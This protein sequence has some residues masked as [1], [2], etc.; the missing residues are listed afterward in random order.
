M[1]LSDTTHTINAIA[2]YGMTIAGNPSTPGYDVYVANDT[3]SWGSSV[4]SNAQK[5]GYFYI[6]GFS[7]QGRYV[8]LQAKD[9]GIGI[10]GFREI[11]IFGQ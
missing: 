4:A 6:E 10:T 7:K 9:N 11:G 8:K 3:T 5:N 1:D 2:V